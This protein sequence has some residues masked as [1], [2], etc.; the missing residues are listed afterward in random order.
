[1]CAKE[2]VPRF[3]RAHN[4][5]GQKVLEQNKG[6]K[7]VQPASEEV[8]GLAKGVQSRDYPGACKEDP[9]GFE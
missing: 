5:K 3:K 6:K 2:G 9:R 4:D 8:I 1:M 7:G